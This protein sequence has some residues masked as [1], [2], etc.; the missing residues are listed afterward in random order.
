MKIF[1]DKILIFNGK[2]LYM[3]LNEF[4]VNTNKK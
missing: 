3:T 2:I 1:N 4:E